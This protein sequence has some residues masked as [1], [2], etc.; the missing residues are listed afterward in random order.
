VLT[1]TWDDL[2]AEIVLRK[3]ELP[4]EEQQR[5]QYLKLREEYRNARQGPGLAAGEGS[6][7]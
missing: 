2:E 7:K 3:L 4:P 6:P 1:Y 5:R